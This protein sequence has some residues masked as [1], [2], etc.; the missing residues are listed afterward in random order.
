MYLLSVTPGLHG[1]VPNKRLGLAEQ[2]A[3]GDHVFCLN[4]AVGYLVDEAEPGADLTEVH[5]Q[6]VSLGKHLKWHRCVWCNCLLRISNPMT[7]MGT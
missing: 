1:L 2:V 5:F 6:L 7:H 4:E 3:V